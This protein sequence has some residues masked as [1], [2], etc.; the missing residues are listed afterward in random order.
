MSKKVR[1]D[2][3]LW[4]IR[5]YKTRTISTTA[6]KKGHVSMG[7]N[8]LKP[9]FLLVEGDIVTARK[10]GFNRV[11]KVINP[12]EKRVGAKIAIDCFE[13]LTPKEELQ[14]YESWYLAG[15]GNEY[16]D[17]GEGRPTKKNRREL[18]DFKTGE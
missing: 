10:E 14:K 4:S 9:S 1:V 6:C 5:V 2:K 3:W 13:E 11:Y 16:R 17:K 12:I 15:K 7:E 8:I 18:D